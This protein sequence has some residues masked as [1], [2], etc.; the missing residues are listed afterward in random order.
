[1]MPSVTQAFLHNATLTTAF[2]EDS[3]LLR[4]DSMLSGKYFLMFWSML[5]LSPSS[6]N[7]NHI[8]TLKHQNYLPG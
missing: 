3:D 8:M 6:L 5:F 1:M 4:R 2:T 7:S